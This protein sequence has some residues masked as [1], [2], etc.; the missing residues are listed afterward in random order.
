MDAETFILSRRDILS[1]LDKSRDDLS[2][3]HAKAAPSLFAGPVATSLWKGAVS[4][5]SGWLMSKLAPTPRGIVS[6]ALQLL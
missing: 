5:A 6:K 3:A 1:R 4:L 2:R